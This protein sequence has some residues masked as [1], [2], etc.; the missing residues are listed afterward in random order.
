[1]VVERIVA[2][3]RCLSFCFVLSFSL[4]AILF[5]QGFAG[6][7]P[8]AQVVSY[9]LK[10]RDDIVVFVKEKTVVFHFRF[11]F[12]SSLSLPRFLVVL[13]TIVGGS[14]LK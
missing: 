6:E 2:V 14:S 12:S 8:E 13:L 3:R 11:S 10:E 1:M 4:S 9:R 5:D 7:R